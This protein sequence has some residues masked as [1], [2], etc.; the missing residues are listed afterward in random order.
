MTKIKHKIGPEK[1]TALMLYEQQKK[2]NRRL[3]IILGIL[4]FWSVI[5]TGI[6]AVI[7]IFGLG[8]VSK[9]Y[10]T[11]EEV[12]SRIKTQTNNAIEDVKDNL[13]HKVEEIKDTVRDEIRTSVNK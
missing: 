1:V 7:A 10:E 6:T 3:S 5:L 12:E 2:A 4:I 9:A 11:V 8:T 13:T